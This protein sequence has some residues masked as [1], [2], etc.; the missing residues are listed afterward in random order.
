M[1]TAW[2]KIF[3]A[4]DRVNILLKKPKLTIDVAI[5]HLQSL[6]EIIENFRDQGIN[7]ALFE[8]K[9]EV[10]ALNALFIT[11]YKDEESN[12]DIEF[13]KDHERRNLEELLKMRLI[14]LVRMKNL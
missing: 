13:P 4:L 6:I 2:N 11:K 8:V 14:I 9:T 5:K 12:I 7:E 1:L 3:S 10:K